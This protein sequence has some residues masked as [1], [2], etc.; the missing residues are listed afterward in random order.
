MDEVSSP[1]ANVTYDPVQPTM[2]Q[3]VEQGTLFELQAYTI[4]SVDSIRSIEEQIKEAGKMLKEALLGNETYRNQE[5]EVKDTAK[6]RNELKKQLME[7][8]E[9]KSLADRIKSLRNEL[10]ERKET[11]SQT[12]L[13][14]SRQSGEERITA[15]D[16]TVY[17]IVKVAKLVKAVQ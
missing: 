7:S 16:G 2:Q 4:K 5:E 6:T 13:E 12:A 9:L 10:K 15:P 1:G 14:Y 11:Q 3:Q 17:E 8:P